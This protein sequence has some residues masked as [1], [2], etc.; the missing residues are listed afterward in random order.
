MTGPGH[1]AAAVAHLDLAAGIETDG[2]DDGMS[3]WHQ[4]Q[5]QAHATLALAAAHLEAILV[6]PGERREWDRAMDRPGEV[7]R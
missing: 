1:Y 4:R 5:A 2:H 6:H 3:A 7:T